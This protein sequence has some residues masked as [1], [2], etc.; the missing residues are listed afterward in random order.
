M[1]V[2]EPREA[3]MISWTVVDGR[4]S[5][6]VGHAMAIDLAEM[7]NMAAVA[8]FLIKI[9]VEVAVIFL[10]KTVVEVV[11][12]VFAVV[13]VVLGAGEV[14]VSFEVVGED[15]IRKGNIIY[16]QNSQCIMLD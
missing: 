6:Q 11:V 1:I 3:G 2:V 7:E 4:R 14:V 9:V 10:I 13:E 8:T 12:A 5:H 16:G 15:D